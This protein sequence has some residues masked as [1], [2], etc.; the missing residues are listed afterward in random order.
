MSTF[1]GLIKNEVYSNLKKSIIERNIE[2][3]LAYVVDLACTKNELSNLINFFTT[4]FCENLLNA[5]SDYVRVFAMK[6]ERLDKMPRKGMLQNKIFQST[7]IDL[8]LLLCIKKSRINKIDHIKNNIGII[9]ADLGKCTFDYQEYEVIDDEFKHNLSIDFLYKMVAIIKLLDQKDSVMCL[10]LV[11]LCVTCSDSYN[12]G[13]LRIRFFN[14]EKQPKF[15]N[16]SFYIWKI[17][18]RYVG[19]NCPNLLPIIAN[20][21]SIYITCLTKKIHTDRINILL[22]CIYL[23]CSGK[24]IDTSSSET[25]S[26]L[27]SFNIDATSIFNNVCNITCNTTPQLPIEQVADTNVVEVKKVNNIKHDYLKC[28][29]FIGDNNYEKTNNKNNRIERPEK[30]ILYSDE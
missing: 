19:Q 30:T 2:K 29:T 6:I 11:Y 22:Y 18:H 14:N 26:K 27:K 4:Y 12:V 28:V 5:S 21:F 9:K 8:Y 16:I 1:K 3:G 7:V 23:I 24:K 13:V 17:I 20:Y 10:G 25:E 15:K